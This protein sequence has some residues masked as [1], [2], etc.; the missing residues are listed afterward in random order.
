MDEDQIRTLLADLLP[1]L[2]ELP[3][4]HLKGWEDRVVRLARAAL[5]LEDWEERLADLVA[6]LEAMID[7]A[8]DEERADRLSRIHAALFPHHDDDD[9]DEE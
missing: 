9:R 1:T 4:E 3:T 5:V 6:G 8:V 7:D 2:E